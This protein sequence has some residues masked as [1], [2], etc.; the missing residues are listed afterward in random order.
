MAQFFRNISDLVYLVGGRTKRTRGRPA[1][2]AMPIIGS[3]DQTSPVG[4]VNRRA[5]VWDL[6]QMPVRPTMGDLSLSVELEELLYWSVEMN[7][8]LRLLSQN[9]FQAKDGRVESWKLRTTNSDGTPL[10][11]PPNERVQKI[12][13]DLAHRTYGKE[14]VLGGQ[15][16]EQAAF[17]AFGRGDCFMELAIENDGLG[18]FYIEKSNYLPTWSIF[19]IEDE[20]GQ[21]YGYRQQSRID[22]S[23]GDVLWQGYDVARMLHFKHSPQQRYGFPATFPNI[24]SWRLYKAASMDLEVASRDSNSF[25]LHQ[26]P[27]ERGADYIN[28]Y[29]A[30][31]EAQLENGIVTHVY[32]PHGADIKRASEANPN[33]KALSDYHLQL[34]FNL[35]LGSFPV[36]LIPGLATQSG[37][38]KELSGAPALAYGRTVAHARSILAQ[39]ILYC[40]GLEYTLNYGYESWCEERRYCEIEWPV[41]VNQEVPGLMPDGSQPIDNN[42]NGKSKE[43]EKA[44][45][46]MTETFISLN[47]DELKRI[48]S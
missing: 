31:F 9:V 41:W 7:T 25:W 5:K 39:E 38:G 20:Y 33:L 1:K 10:E 19:S 3:Q 28:A 26:S 30:E 14:Y 32:L 16:L 27:P 45:E 2:G 40:V 36:Y 35:V 15:K 47:G 43:T 12:A 8:S 37:I 13:E 18:S 48:F 23:E 17:S 21:L 11:R 24:E 6:P 29:R 42:Q 4:R 44:E 22:P 34:R 46:E